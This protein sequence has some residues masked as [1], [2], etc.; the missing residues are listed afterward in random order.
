MS[1][2][3]RYVRSDSDDYYILKEE[4][5]SST[6]KHETS[7]HTENNEKVELSPPVIKHV[8]TDSLDK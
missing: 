2:N 4:T 1:D 8:R 3:K 6:V 7:L 5:I